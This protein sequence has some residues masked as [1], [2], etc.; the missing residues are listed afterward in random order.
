MSIYEEEVDMDREQQNADKNLRHPD[1]MPPLGK[2]IP[3]GIQHVLAMFA[4]NITPPIII[5]GAAGLAAPG[6]GRPAA[7]RHLYLFR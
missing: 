2:A 5:A 6:G 1:Y 7:R 4:S 3:L